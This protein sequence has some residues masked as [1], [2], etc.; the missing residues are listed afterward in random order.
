MLTVE[1]AKERILHHISKG[2]ITDRA[3][4]L[5]AIIS[6]Y[7]VYEEDTVPVEIL[8]YVNELYYNNTIKA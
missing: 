2:Y 4:C 6:I 7:E 5:Q 3:E 8:K 1:K